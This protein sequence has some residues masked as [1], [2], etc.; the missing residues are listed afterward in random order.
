MLNLSRVSALIERLGGRVLLARLATLQYSRRDPARHF[1]VDSVGHWVNAQAEATIVSPVPHTAAYQDFRAWVLDHWCHGYLPKPGDTVIDVGAGVGEEAVVFSQLVGPSGRVI[2]IEAHP[3]IYASLCETIRRSGLSNVTPLCIAVGDHEG[4]VHFAEGE[5]FLTGSIVRGAAR[6]LAEV[7]LQTLDRIAADHALGKVALIKMNIEGAELGA[8]A[9]M[10]E[11]A[12]RT[13]NV[14]ISCHDF[15]A[16]RGG[17]DTLRTR[18]QVMP[19]LEAYGYLVVV[20]GDHPDAWA[21]DYLYG[22]RG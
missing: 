1:S 8:V 22:S 11:L 10:S 5:N 2:A 17:E 16:E 3:G 7:P 4:A 9:G 20:R 12:G 21:R 15:L 18:E 13:R 19:M 6:E 14:I